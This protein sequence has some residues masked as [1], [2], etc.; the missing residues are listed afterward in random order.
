MFGAATAPALILVALAQRLPSLPKRFS[1]AT[2]PAF[3]GAVLIGFGIVT[4]LRGTAPASV[5]ARCPNHAEPGLAA[6]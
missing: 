6:P 5:G 3:L 4:F 1:V 2:R